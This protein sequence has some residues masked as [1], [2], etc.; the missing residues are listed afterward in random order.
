M[1]LWEWF[2]RTPPSIK[3]L[4]CRRTG[5]LPRLW[6]WVPSYRTYVPVQVAGTAWDAAQARIQLRANKICTKWLKDS[7]LWLGN[8]NNVT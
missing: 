2:L 1:S 3:K 4:D 8:P 6:V 7:P 5:R